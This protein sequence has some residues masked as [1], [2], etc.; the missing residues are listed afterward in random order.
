MLP[1]GGP[2]RLV[3]PQ[4]VAE[5]L[6]ELLIVR[7]EVGPQAGHGRLADPLAA[8]D[9]VGDRER[10]AAVGEA[11]PFQH[12]SGHSRIA[13][14]PFALHHQHALAPGGVEPP[15]ELWR[16]LAAGHVRVGHVGEV[17]L[18]PDHLIGVGGDALGLAVERLI[19]RL[20]TGCAQSPP[21]PVVGDGPLD[22]VAEKGDEAGVGEGFGRTI[23]R[24]GVEQQVRSRLTSD[25]AG[26]SKR[27]VRPVPP[28]TPVVVVVEEVHLLPPGRAHV[29]AIGEP[30]IEGG[31]AAPLRPDDDEI[32][33]G[34]EPSGGVASGELDPRGDPLAHRFPRRQWRITAH[35][36]GRHRPRRSDDVGW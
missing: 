33:K 27:E 14:E 28:Q 15:T 10:V 2:A 6:E 24:Q 23:R 21:Q 1:A 22:R 4:L 31:G 36:P 7:L 17:H 5:E 30:S 32:G 3:R 18:A 13:G 29:G 16:V 34:T 35:L 11:E 9:L 8:D 25:P 20:V 12:A 26:T 19:E